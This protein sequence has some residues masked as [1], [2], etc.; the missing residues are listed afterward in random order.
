MPSPLGANINT[1][2]LSRLSG[3]D[4]MS[5]EPEHGVVEVGLGWDGKTSIPTLTS[6]TLPL[7]EEQC[8]TSGW[9]THTRR[10]PVLSPEPA[11]ATGQTIGAVMNMVYLR[12]E[13]NPAASAPFASI[14]TIDNLTRIQT[15]TQMM[16]GQ[17][18][19]LS[20]HK[21]NPKSPLYNALP[22]I[23]TA[24]P[25]VQTLQSVPNGV[26]ALGPQSICARAIAA[27][28]SRGGN[29]LG[30]QSTRQTWLSVDAG[31]DNPDDDE[32]VHSAV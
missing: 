24:T 4:G 28:H 12:P 1:G 11:F 22:G 21:L 7:W 32:M 17:M 27:A 30:L 10:R 25:Q 14:P 3:V 9:G 6:T 8:L 18:L 16:S 29:A 23:M 13:P 15:L 26:L 20:I 31:W 5:Y 19:G 2:V